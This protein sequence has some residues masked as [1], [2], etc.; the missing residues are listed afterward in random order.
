MRCGW[1]GGR[2][3]IVGLAMDTVLRVPEAARAS[4]HGDAFAV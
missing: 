1:G 4:E 2:E 3:N